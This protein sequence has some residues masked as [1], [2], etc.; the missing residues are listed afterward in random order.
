MATK[1]TDVLGQA[2]AA[3]E[4]EIFGEANDLATV[5]EDET[6]D[7]SREHM[8]EGLEGQVED[9]EAESDGEVLAADDGAEA[10]A[11]HADEADGKDEKRDPKTGQ[12]IAKD[13]GEG[14][15]PEANADAANAGK[16][17][18]DA[19]GRVPPG[20]L[21]EANE[22]ARTAEERATAA[23][24][25][26]EA[27]LSEGRA[28][29]DEVRALNARLDGILAAMQAR[30][31]AD[32]KP[33]QTQE[34]VPDLLVDPQGF[35]SHLTSNL[36]KGFQQELA[37]RDQRFESLRVE[38][39]MQ[40]AHDK[41]GDTFAKAY[42]AIN[43]LD[44]R[45]P[46]DQVTVRRIWSSPNPGDALV[47]WHKNNETIK[48]VGDDPSAFEE[49]IRTATRESLMKDPEF[50]KQ[51]IADLRAEADGNGGRPNTVTRM[52][53]S[54]NGASGGNA[55]NRPSPLMTDDSDQAAFE[56]AFADD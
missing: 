35:V 28:A 2:I 34:E 37:A 54:L 22:R 14:E 23:E 31:N 46:D 45:N 52:P 17:E 40:M 55:A 12:F 15:T 50:R 38:T 44:P 42:E 7:R 10:D 48:R 25:A 47:R 33:Q 56:N 36:T 53:K 19:R 3:T 43:G 30:P 5:I 1:E 26:R 4:Q 51:V 18:A 6:G 20:R 8:G 49:N 16:G 9:D 32:A 27:A 11:E 39:S 29:R 13:K 21:R 24:A 41:H